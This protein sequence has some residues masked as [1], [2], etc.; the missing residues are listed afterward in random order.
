MINIGLLKWNSFKAQLEQQPAQ[1]L[2]FQYAE[3]KWVNANYHITEIKQSE[4]TSVDCGGKLD[5]WTEIIVQLWEPVANNDTR[6]MEVSKALSIVEVVEGKMT[7]DE[8]AIVKIEFGNSDFDTRQMY[9]GDFVLEGENLIINLL[10]DVTQCKA[11]ERGGSCGPSDAEDPCCALAP[12]EM[13][14]VEM[15]NL[16]AESNCYTPSE[17]CC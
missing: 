12:Q 4:I 8:N 3:H 17:G 10:A 9:P 15:I 11:I 13:E 16:V 2:Q 5:R 7:L 6:A 14:K 1:L